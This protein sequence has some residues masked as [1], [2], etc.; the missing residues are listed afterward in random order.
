MSGGFDDAYQRTWAG[1]Q[2]GQRKGHFNFK[3]QG[4]ERTH[5]H[6]DDDAMALKDPKNLKRD[7]AYRS[8]GYRSDSE[9]RGR[10]RRSRSRGRGDGGGARGGR[11]G[12]RDNFNKGVILTSSQRKRS[13]AAKAELVGKVNNRPNKPKVNT[14]IS[15]RKYMVDEIN[16]AGRDQG[17]GKDDW[18]DSWDD[19]TQRKKV[20]ILI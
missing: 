2:P 18:W 19:K 12:M 4:F 6:L 8:S 14:K 15:G 20:I 16:R 5:E 13:D 10:R 1:V 11:G 3:S 9:G 7:S 17:R